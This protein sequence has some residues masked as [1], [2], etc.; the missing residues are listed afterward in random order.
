MCPF[1]LVMSCYDPLRKQERL[2]STAGRAAV[3]EG[4]RLAPLAERVTENASGCT[5]E[6]NV[7]TTMYH[8]AI[9]NLLLRTFNRM[10]V[11]AQTPKQP[12]VLSYYAKN[13][14]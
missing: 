12:S 3:S 4:E 11:K 9:S 14:K 13:G 1:C 10:Q 6:V 7:Y 8:A 5:Y 2:L